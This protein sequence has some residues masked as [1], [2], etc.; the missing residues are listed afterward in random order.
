[1]SAPKHTPTRWAA[2]FKPDGSWYICN[3][4]SRR[5]IDTGMTEQDAKDIVKEH[6]E[7]IKDTA[8]PGRSPSP[9][10]RA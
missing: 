9:T 7:A 8:P 2:D 1:M 3:A 5:V 4:T 10:G 6:N